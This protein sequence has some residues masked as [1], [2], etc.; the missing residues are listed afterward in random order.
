[1]HRDVHGSLVA[2]QGNPEAQHGGFV[3]KTMAH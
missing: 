1:M 3:K 2:K